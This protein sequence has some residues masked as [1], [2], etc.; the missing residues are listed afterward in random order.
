[1]TTGFQGENWIVP[2]QQGNTTSQGLLQKNPTENHKLYLSQS[3]SF[4]TTVSVSTN[5]LKY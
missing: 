2:L 5:I 4:R 3:F 1:M